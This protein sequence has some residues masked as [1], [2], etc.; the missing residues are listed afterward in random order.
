MFGWKK[1]KDGQL[2]APVT[3]QMVSLSDVPDEVFAQKMLG[4]GGA[5][6]MTDGQIVSPADGTVTEV[7][8]TLHAYGITTD[9]GLDVLVHVGIDTVSLKGEGFTALV[10]KGDRVS[11]GQPLANVDLA[12]LQQHDLPLYTPVIV[13]NMDAVKSI[14]TETGAAQAGQT[15]LLHYQQ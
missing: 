12:V 3:G 6:K 4:D 10:K 8:D 1:A 13:T 5:V 15:V 9:S 14:S 2:T 7:T 11:A